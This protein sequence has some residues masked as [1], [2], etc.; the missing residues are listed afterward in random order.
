MVDAVFTVDL[1]EKS[2]DTSVSSGHGGAGGGGGGGGA[3]LELYARNHDFKLKNL[4]IFDDELL[5]EIIWNY[6]D[7]GRYKGDPS[8]SYRIQSAY[9]PATSSVPGKFDPNYLLL[10]FAAGGGGGGG[11]GPCTNNTIEIDGRLFRTGRYQRDMATAKVHDSDYGMIPTI[12]S[13][14]ADWHQTGTSNNYQLQIETQ[15]IRYKT[16][17]GGGAGAHG[18]HEDTSNTIGG[19]GTDNWSSGPRKYTPLD[20][21]GSCLTSSNF[22]G[23]GGFSGQSVYVAFPNFETYYGTGRYSQT[24]FTRRL[25]LEQSFIVLES[26]G[27]SGIGDGFAMITY[28]LT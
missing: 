19:R 9:V 13:G 1:M 20:S 3:A 16:G 5:E 10:A 18:P 27:Y 6:G 28:D 24:L 25:P 26:E 15:N 11:Q 8:R 14:Y 22:P 12:Q 23:H 17:G 7:G 21:N 4:N 2:G